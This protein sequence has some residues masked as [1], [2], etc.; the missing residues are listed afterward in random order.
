MGKPGIKEA[1]TSRDAW[2]FAG[3]TGKAAFGLS[4]AN[5]LH[6]QPDVSVTC[7]REPWGGVESSLRRTYE[8]TP[9]N[10]NCLRPSF[11]GRS[12]HLGVLYDTQI[13]AQVVVAG[14]VAIKVVIEP[15][16]LTLAGSSVTDVGPVIPRPLQL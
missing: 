10:S 2:C 16:V 7:G 14:V 1:P 11:A 3:P 13:H 15:S 4:S 9:S 6:G 8:F 12:S 5:S